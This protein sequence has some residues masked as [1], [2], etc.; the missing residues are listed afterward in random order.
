MGLYPRRAVIPA[1]GHGTRLLPLTRAVPKELLPAGV[2]PMVHRAVAEAAAAGL[3]EVCIVLRRGKETIRQYFEARG[4]REDGVLAAL[5]RRCAIRFRV[6]PQPLGLGHAVWCARDFVGEEP[7]V[8]IVPDQFLV[9]PRSGTEQLLATARRIRPP[10]IVSSLVRIPREDLPCIPGARGFAGMPPP[11]ARPRVPFPLGGLVPEA[12]VRRQYI[13]APYEVRGFGRTVYPPEI[14]RW[15]GPA[16]RN[17]ASGEVDLA[18]TFRAA[19]A[20][21]PHWGVLLRGRAC[22]LGTWAGYQR[23]FPVLARPDDQEAAPC[24]W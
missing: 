4:G 1:A 6:Q 24:G 16:F 8:L 23:F 19:L 9:G 3:T 22:D 5:R 15:L 13:A 7:F 2:W 20:V 21:L 18:P 14:L 11:G 10:A 17:P 12:T